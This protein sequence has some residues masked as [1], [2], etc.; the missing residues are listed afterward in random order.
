M[1]QEEKDMLDIIY[2]IA[3]SKYSY[4]CLVDGVAETHIEAVNIFCDIEEIG[5]EITMEEVIQ[6]LESAI[7]RQESQVILDKENYHVPRKLIEVE[8]DEELK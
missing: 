2:C 1:S 4:H 5:I 6:C 3:L 7:F 8:I